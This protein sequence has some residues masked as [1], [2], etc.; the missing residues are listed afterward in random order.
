MRR[1]DGRFGLDAIR[2]RIQSIGRAIDAP[3][4][5]LPTYGSSRDFARPHIE[6]DERG[7]HY[8]VVERGR[9]LERRTFGSIED[10]LYE[11]FRH[12]CS[13]LAADYEAAH[14][15]AGEDF[16]R[17]MFER[18]LALMASLSQEWA[19]RERRRIDAI[20]LEHPYRDA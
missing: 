13:T 7:Y 5:Y 19:E 20:L 8:V 16:R 12:V 17:Q 18:Q 6:V 15:I 11:V 2:R 10:L 14:R 9:E 3:D 4:E 1:R